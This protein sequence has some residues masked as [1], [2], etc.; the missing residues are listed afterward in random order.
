MESQSL[1]RH[2]AGQGLKGGKG[3]TNLLVINA[4][5]CSERPRRV[6]VGVAP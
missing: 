3:D 1:G 4:Q 6:L 5:S 2:T